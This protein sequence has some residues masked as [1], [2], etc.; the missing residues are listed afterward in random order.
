MNIKEHDLM[1]IEHESIEIILVM[2]GKTQEQAH[3]LAELEF[4]Y[5]EATEKYYRSLKFTQKR[6]HKET[7]IDYKSII[8]LKKLQK[9]SDLRKDEKYNKPQK[10]NEGVR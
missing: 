8:K 9:A 4:N 5:T 6:H 1:L 10:K 3:K 2:Q 7:F